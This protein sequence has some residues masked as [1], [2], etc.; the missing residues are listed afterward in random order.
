MADYHDLVDSGRRERTLAPA[1]IIAPVW[2]T[3]LIVL[4]RFL[5]PDYSHMRM[6]I[7]AVDDGTPLHPWAGLFQR[8]LVAV[9][10][11]CTIVLV[12]RLRAI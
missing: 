8:I 4:Q 6:P 9:G 2:F 10:F 5:L 12:V 11:A 1:G 3:T 7:F